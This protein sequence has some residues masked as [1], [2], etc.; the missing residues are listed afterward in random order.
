[1]K[2]VGRSDLITYIPIVVC[3]IVDYLICVFRVFLF[4][5][6]GILTLVHKYSSFMFIVVGG[7]S[8]SKI[9]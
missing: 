9:L 4:L 7:Y 3:C 1:M 5:Y 6:Y 8:G 2:H